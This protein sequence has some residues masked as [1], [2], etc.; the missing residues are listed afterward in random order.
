VRSLAGG[1]GPLILAQARAARTAGN[2]SPGTGPA[3]GAATSP[4]LGGGDWAIV[5]AIQ[6]SLQ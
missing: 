5:L 3:V 4:G 1:G 6:A 2:G